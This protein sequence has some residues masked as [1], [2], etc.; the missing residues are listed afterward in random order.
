MSVQ[1]KNK[2]LNH[3][4]MQSGD[5]GIKDVVLG[6]GRSVQSDGANFPRSYDTAYG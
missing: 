4:G 5:E 3:N 6:E 2:Q 1:S